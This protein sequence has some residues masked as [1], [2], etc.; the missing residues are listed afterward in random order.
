MFNEATD[1]SSNTDRLFSKQRIWQATA[2]FTLLAAPISVI[3]WQ[4]GAS[5]SA[6]QYPTNTMQTSG[7]DGN[8]EGTQ[9]GADANH[10]QHITIQ[11]NS[12][13]NSSS[14]S[15]SSASQQSSLHVDAST[16]GTGGSSSSTNL[17][18]NGRQV[19]IPTSGTVHKT[20][21]GSNVDIS[22]DSTATGGSSTYHSLNINTDTNINDSDNGD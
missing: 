10:S 14:G 4:H 7:N 17:W 22:V 3:A 20:I 5:T 15:G 16:N 8:N 2:A 13:S 21:N 12:S 19:P 6:A 9:S 18:V 11:S 1:E